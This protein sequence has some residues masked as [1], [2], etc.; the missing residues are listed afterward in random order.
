MDFEAA[1]INRAY[2]RDEVPVTEVI[3]S[4]SIGQAEQAL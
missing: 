2:A 4:R 1:R 3:G